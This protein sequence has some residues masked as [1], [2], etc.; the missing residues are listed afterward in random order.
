MIT[1]IILIFILC[2][3][4]GFSPLKLVE[5]VANLFLFLIGLWVIIAFIFAILAAIQ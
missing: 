4:L 2:H 1:A 3:F 5:K